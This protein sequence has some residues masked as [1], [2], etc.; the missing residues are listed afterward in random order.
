MTTAPPLARSLR[1]A[2]G[3][4]RYRRATPPVGTPPVADRSRES[5]PLMPPGN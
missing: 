1:R 4:L 5:H 3:Q 2:R